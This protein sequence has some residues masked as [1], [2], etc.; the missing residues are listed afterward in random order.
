ML[1]KIIS[2]LLLGSMVFLCACAPSENSSADTVSFTDALGREV[3]VSQNPKRVAA[4]LGS[5]A[6]IWLLAGGEVCATADDAWEDFGLSLDGVVNIGG[7][8]SP[9]LELLISSDPYLV[10]ASASTASN[11]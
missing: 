11:V 10:I 6:D 4:L 1:K 2:I 3:K 5:F 8:H 9:S 7:A